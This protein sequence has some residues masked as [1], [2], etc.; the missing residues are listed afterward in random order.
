MVVGGQCLALAGLP[1]G[2]GPSIHF[3]G[4]WLW[5]ILPSLGF[6]LRTV[7]SIASHCTNCTML[8]LVLCVGKV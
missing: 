8:A 4:G 7:Q 1:L 6:N 3:T 5:K 2:K